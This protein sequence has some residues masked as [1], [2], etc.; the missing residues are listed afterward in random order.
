M[1]VVI[2]NSL[3]RTIIA[4]TLSFS[5]N[6]CGFL[7]Y[8]R[9]LKH[10]LQAGTQQPHPMVLNEKVYAKSKHSLHCFPEEFHNQPSEG[11]FLNYHHTNLLRLNGGFAII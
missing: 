6:F 8:H 10:R 1:S 9:H 2:N 7:K 5:I 3:G 4:S 11:H